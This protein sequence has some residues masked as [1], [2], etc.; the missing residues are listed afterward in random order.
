MRN[1]YKDSL[2]KNK[3]QCG[4]HRSTGE[5]IDHPECD[6]IRDGSVAVRGAGQH[7]LQSEKQ[8][9]LSLEKIRRTHGNAK[10]LYKK[11][12]QYIFQVFELND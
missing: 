8:S 2:I 4:V 12:K 6:R 11:G 7:D 1:N 3:L 9:P 10:V 5:R